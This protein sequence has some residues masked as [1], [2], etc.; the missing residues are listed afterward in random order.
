MTVEGIALEAAKTAAAREIA[1]KTVGACIDYLGDKAGLVKLRRFKSNYIDYCDKI[2]HIRTLASQEKP[3]FIDDI[4]VPISI[5]KA[6]HTVSFE[7]MDKTTLDD[8]KALL[9]KGL[10]GQGKSTILRKLMSN[11][12][13]EY[14]RLPIFYELKNYRGGAIEEALSVHFKS[15]GVDIDAESV[16]RLLQDSNVKVFLDAFDETNPKYRAELLDAIRG[17][18]NRYQCHIICTSRPDTEIDSL[19]EVRTYTVCPLNENQIF[20]II[21]ST[22]VDEEKANE[23]CSALKRSPLH[24]DSESILK[25]PILVVL[26][27]VSYNLGEEIPNTLSQFYSN[28]FETVF[29]RH[30]NIKGK[31]NRVRHWNDNRRIYRDLFN[32][33]CFIS[34]RTGFGSFNKEKFSQFVSDSLDYVG[35]N[36]KLSDKISDEISSITNLIIEDGFNEYRYV[37]KSIQEFFSASFICG[38][39]YEKK[40]GFYKKCVQSHEFFSIFSNTLFFLQEL[41]YIDY[42]ENYFIPSVNCLLAIEKSPI[43][44]DFKIPDALTELYKD[45]MILRGRVNKIKS[46]SSKKS[47]RE[48]I[49]ENPHFSDAQKMPEVFS[50]LFNFSIN[51]LEL[52]NENDELTKLI[53]ENGISDL[54][55]W[56]SL[57]IGDLVKLKKLQ[58]P[59]IENS[60]LIGIEALFRKQYNQA[61]EKLENRIQSLADSGYFDF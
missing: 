30:D 14:N 57:P 15:M 52:K 46:K 23:L 17:I 39:G 12:A 21:H 4:Y 6:G 25:S 26:F 34:Q 22:S 13:K 33:L 41:D 51:H 29:Y 20:G 27:C 35:E 44:D 47:G 59:A 9:I 49:I 60:L 10:A 56:V 31:V 16:S 50:R 8:T 36:P 43:G 7:V 45:K 3:V 61:I 18:I 42:C 37:H 58:N 48:Y 55:G 1:K 53:I 32:C 38:M 40:I 2:L 19:T 24:K 28:I 54:E 11:N 5:V